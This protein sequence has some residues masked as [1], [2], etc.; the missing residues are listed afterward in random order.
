VEVGIVSFIP[1]RLGQGDGIS[2]LNG[3]VYLHA[4]HYA[5]AAGQ[6]AHDMASRDPVQLLE[7]D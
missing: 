4:G 2:T 5:E 3:T 6:P 1:L 7:D